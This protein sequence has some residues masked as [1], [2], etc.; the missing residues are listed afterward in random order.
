M[1]L[2]SAIMAPELL[3]PDRRDRVIDLYLV[4]P[5]T[6]TDY[7]LARFFAFFVIVLAL[8]YSGQIVLL[9]GLILTSA[10]PLDYLRD[11]WQDI[12]RVIGAGVLVALFV[13]V[14][15]LAVAG[16]TTRRAVAS[17]FIIGLFFISSA[18]ADGLTTSTD[19]TFSEG[20]TVCESAT[21]DAAKWFALISMSAIPL[22][23]N[24]MVFDAE[25]D[26]PSV[27][28]SE[29]L[30]D[31]IPIAVYALFTIGPGLLLWR[32]YRRLQI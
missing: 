24:D 8:A 19:C 18:V 21:G 11:N 2:F 17:V 14:I 30:H 13:T 23:M 6:S 4:R 22:R 7:L 1:L 20:E 9:A 12:P 5:L 3:A 27:T 26:A 16:F 32:Q 31:S 29:E 10:E 28:A 25:S 15:P